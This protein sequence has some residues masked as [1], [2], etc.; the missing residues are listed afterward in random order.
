MFFSQVEIDAFWNALTPAWNRR[1]VRIRR[2]FARPFVGQAEFLGYLQQ[3]AHEVRDGKRGIDVQMIDDDV[4]PCAEDQ[5]LDAFERRI[6]PRW[7]RDWYLYI[8]DGIQQFDGDLWERA[9]ELLTPALRLHGGL[10]SGGMTLDLF[11]GKYQ[12]TPTGI[13]LDSSDSLAFVVRGPKRLLFWPRDCFVA[14]FASPPK[15]PSHQQALTGRY[16]DYLDDAVIV[17]AEEGDVVYWPKDFWHIGTSAERWS[18][19]IALGMWWSATPSK[20]ARSVLGGMLDLQSESQLYT[21]DLDDMA[22][23]ALELPAALDDTMSQVKNQ[24]ERRLGVAARFAWAKFVTGYGFSTPP[25]PREKPSL[26]DSTR[27]RVKH[28]IVR[29]DLG[30][31]VAVIACGQQ[32]VTW[33]LTLLPAIARLRVGSEHLVSDLIGLLPDGDADAAQ[34]LHDLVREL[35]GFRALEVI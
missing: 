9:I 11:Y 26:G 15:S 1:P 35:A 34:R 6:A 24:V 31:A 5:S 16:V 19:M 17:D 30:R 28:P 18:G 33:C 13:H 20:L 23:A 22:S 7:T 2:P 3:W 10:P 4:L 32:T 14:K 12:L 29:I 8:P 25:A 21:I 27:V